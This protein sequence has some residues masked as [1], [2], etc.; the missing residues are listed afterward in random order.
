MHGAAWLTQHKT[1]YF[2]KRLVEG[3][4]IIPT[5]LISLIASIGKT[6]TKQTSWLL[7]HKRTLPID[8]LPLV[9]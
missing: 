4:I 7:V 8:R 5:V 2:S 1:S 3:A 9:S 6:K